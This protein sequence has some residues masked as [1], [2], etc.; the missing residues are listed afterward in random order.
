MLA[1]DT[2][3]AQRLHDLVWQCQAGDF[4]ALRRIL[5]AQGRQTTLDGPQMTVQGPPMTVAIL[6][7][8]DPL[9]CFTQVMFALFGELW[10]LSAITREALGQ[11]KKTWHTATQ[12]QHRAKRTRQESTPC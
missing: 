12:I 3:C 6:A 5:D 9:C 1:T 10:A 2:A 4:A 7:G 11:V 8:S